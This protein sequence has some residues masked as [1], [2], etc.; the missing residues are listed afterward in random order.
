MSSIFRSHT[1]Q[2][3]NRSNEGP[4]FVLSRYDPVKKKTISQ[5]LTSP[6]EVEQVQKDVAAYNGM[7]PCVTSLKV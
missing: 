5:R 6:E 4:Y 7:W 2:C 1:W 3:G